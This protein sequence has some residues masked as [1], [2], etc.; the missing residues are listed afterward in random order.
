MPKVFWI[1]MWF[2]GG[3][4]RLGKASGKK[5]QKMWSKRYWRDHLFQK[6]EFSGVSRGDWRQA[7]LPTVS[8][9]QVTGWH[10]SQGVGGCGRWEISAVFMALLCVIELE[11][12]FFNCLSF[13]HFIDYHFMSIWG[14]DVSNLQNNTGQKGQAWKRKKEEIMAL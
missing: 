6:L 7:P 11:L 4:S 3:R 12:C 1:R 13:Y 10:V 9:R 5:K 2:S 8:S 14:V